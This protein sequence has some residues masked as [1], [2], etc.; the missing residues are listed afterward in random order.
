[1]TT[2][3][4]QETSLPAIVTKPW[5]REIIWALTPDYAAKV[6]EIKQGHKL[7]LQYHEIKQESIFVESGQLLLILED[8][9]GILQEMN[10]KIGDSQ[11]IARGK[12]HRMVATTDCRIFEVS[13]PHLQDVIRLEDN[14]GRA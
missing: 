3:H 6:L 4:F 12:K 1:M 2:N 14:Y 11:L 10:L 7:S 5:G 13:T 8:E 9:T